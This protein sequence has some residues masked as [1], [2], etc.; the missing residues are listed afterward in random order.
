M[1]G[2]GPGPG[3]GGRLAAQTSPKYIDFDTLYGSKLI[4]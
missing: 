1:A 2:M 4:N 3:L